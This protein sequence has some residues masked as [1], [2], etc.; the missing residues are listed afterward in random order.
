LDVPAVH[1]GDGVPAEARP[2]AALHRAVPL[3]LA[4]QVLCAKG[5][6]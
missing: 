1:R 6:R 3:L 2:A 4:A 5:E